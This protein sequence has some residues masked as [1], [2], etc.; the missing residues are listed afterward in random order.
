MSGTLEKTAEARDVRAA[1]SSALCKSTM[2]D[3]EGQLAD[4]GGKPG[5]QGGTS[6]GGKGNQGHKDEA[7]EAGAHQGLR[8]HTSSSWESPGKQRTRA[9][10][11]EQ[12]RQA[13]GQG[14]IGQRTLPGLSR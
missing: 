2:L 8:E 1:R 9:Q 3:Q 10:V 12:G 14:P 4:C 13:K 6:E 7:G 5:E 11:K